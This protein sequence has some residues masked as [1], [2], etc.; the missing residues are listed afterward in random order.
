[1]PAEAD[2][3]GNSDADAGGESSSVYFAGAL[4]AGYGRLSTPDGTTIPLTKHAAYSADISLGI[5]FGVMIFGVNGEY[6]IWRQI[7]EPEKVGNVNSQGTLRDVYPMAGLEARILRLIWKVPVSLLGD[8]TFKNAGI[9]NQRA[10]YNDPKT[11]ALQLHLRTSQHSFW[12]IEY[13]KATFRN[14]NILE[15]DQLITSRKHMDLRV[16]SLLYGLDL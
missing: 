12:G 6:A 3:D 14:A 16:I 1:M 7:T 11:L 2:N 8:Y 15:V 5:R 10:V 13:Q 4:K 9:T